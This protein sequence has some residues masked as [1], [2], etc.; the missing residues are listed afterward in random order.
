LDAIKKTKNLAILGYYG[1]ANTGDEAILDCLLQNLSIDFPEF[2]ITVFSSDVPYTEKHHNI[3][4]V[5]SSLP[6]G[7][8][9]LMLRSIGRNR[10]N[11][12][13]T[14]STF[15]KADVLLVG[16]GGLFHDTPQGNRHFLNVLHKIVWAKRLGIRVAVLSVTV[17]PLHFEESKHRLREAMNGVDLIT[18]REQQ[19]KD[20]LSEIGL[21]HPKTFVTGDVVHL[22]Q[23]ANEGR[24]REIVRDEGLDAASFPIIGVS[25][26]AYQ[27]NYPGR[28]QSIAAFCDY[29]SSRYGAHIWFIPMQTSALDDDRNEARAVLRLAKNPGAIKCIEGRYAPRETLGL[30][31]KTQAMLAERLHGSIMAI[32]AN[33][34]CFGIGYSPKVTWLFDKIGQ[35]GHHMPLKELSAD[36][37]IAGFS[38]FW[39]RR[40]QTKRELETISMRLKSEARENFYHLKER[41]ATEYVPNT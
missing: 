20:L 25:L 19:S 36:R 41:L 1:S 7:F 26:C 33:V 31:G 24:I 27:R 10:K 11:F 15:V 6:N 40:E 3:S 2:R 13:G 9:D 23:P 29:A 14:L 5:Q 30:I 28:I 17:G 12:Y 39:Q 16:G 8:Y 37:L 35:P 22:L 18:V 32:N 34:P 4:A 38:G 21:S